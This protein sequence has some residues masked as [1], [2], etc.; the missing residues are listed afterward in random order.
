MFMS[1][2]HLLV[3]LYQNWLLSKNTTKPLQ[4]LLEML[5]SY[6]CSLWFHVLALGV[7]TC[8]SSNQAALGTTSR[9][10]SHLCS[11]IF[12]YHHHN[13]LFTQHFFVTLLTI[14]SVPRLNE[15]LPDTPD[16]VLPEPDPY[17]LFTIIRFSL[18]WFLS[19][20][21]PRHLG[22][23][24]LKHQLHWQPLHATTLMLWFINKPVH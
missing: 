16:P 6:W 8:S 22:L 12:P 4:N 18:C 10:P 5:S 14:S 2:I 19:C 20:C 7:L 1:F 15:C 24:H 13:F 3:R 21:L 23:P 11:C 9:L 17:F